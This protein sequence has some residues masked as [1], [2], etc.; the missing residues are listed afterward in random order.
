LPGAGI[1]GAWKA[2]VLVA[3]VAAVLCRAFSLPVP[4]WVM[5]SVQLLGSLTVPL[6]LISLGYA[7]SSIPARGLKSGG[8][9]ATL[10]LV[11]GALAGFS[12]A[13][14][15]GLGGDMRGL[16]V[17]QMTMPCGVRSYI[18]ATRYTDQGDV[19][20]GAVLLS[21]LGFIVL[22]PLIL[23]MVGAPLSGATP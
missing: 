9:V 13:G 2:P 22:S 23:A 7:L 3:S 16:L 12:A 10:R 18:F 6:M 8:M 17:L 14:M 5:E 20:A 19:S 4:Q 15:L 11:I 1:K 21:R